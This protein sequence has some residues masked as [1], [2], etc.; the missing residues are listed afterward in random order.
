MT[1]KVINDI[2]DDLFGGLNFGSVSESDKKVLIAK[3]YRAV[4]DQAILRFMEE[5]TPEQKAELDELEKQND[6]TLIDQFIEDNYGV[7]EGL[8]REEALNLRNE[9]IAKFGK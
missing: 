2:K 5:A 9:L 4:E 1:D 8:F 3:M 6:Q 7:L